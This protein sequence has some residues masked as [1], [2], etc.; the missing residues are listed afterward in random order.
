M[1]KSLTYDEYQGSVQPIRALNGRILGY[2]ARETAAKDVP[3]A[4]RCARWAIWSRNAEQ[5]RQ[6]ASHSGANMKW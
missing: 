5:L 3:R 1:L 4:L 6:P 2:G